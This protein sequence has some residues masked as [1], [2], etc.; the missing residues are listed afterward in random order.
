[1]YFE[2]CVK[3]VKLSVKTKNKQDYISWENPDYLDGYIQN[4]NTATNNLLKENSRLRKLH[5]RVIDSICEL[6]GLDMMRQREQWLERLNG[7]RRL[8]ELA[9][10]EKDPNLCRKWKL[11]CDVQLY[12]VLEIQYLRGIEEFDSTSIDINVEVVFRGKQ[13]SLRPAL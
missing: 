7:L 1:M 9:C 13:I 6:A 8:I 2:E 3:S 4:L 5:I 12:K 10:G 11:H